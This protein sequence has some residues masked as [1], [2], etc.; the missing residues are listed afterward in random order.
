[1]SAQKQTPMGMDHLT[2]VPENFEG[3]SE[4]DEE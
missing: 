3:R 2:V 4:D 1:M